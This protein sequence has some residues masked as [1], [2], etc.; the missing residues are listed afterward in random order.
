[1][2]QNL[3]KLFLIV[4]FMLLFLS[5]KIAHAFLTGTNTIVFTF[6]ILN[7]ADYWGN[8]S[9]DKD[10]PFIIKDIKGLEL[11]RKYMQVNSSDI[12]AKYFKLSGD[13]EYDDKDFTPIGSEVYPFRGNFDGNNYK[14]SG[15]NY[16]GDAQYVGLFGYVD[17]GFIENL[18]LESC[19][20]E[21]TCSNAIVGSIAG[22]ISADKI[23]NCVVVSGCVKAL[24]GTAGGIVGVTGYNAEIENCLCL[25]EEV[26]GLTQGAVI[27]NN[28]GNVTLCYFTGENLTDHEAKK[29]HTISLDK[30]ANIEV[31]ELV[32]S[33]DINLESVDKIQADTNRLIYGGQ[34]YAGA[35]VDVTIRAIPEELYSI[36][37]IEPT[38]GITSGDEYIFSMPDEDVI[39]RV[40]TIYNVSNDSSDNIISDDL[41]LSVDVSVDTNIDINIDDG[42]LI[43]ADNHSIRTLELRNNNNITFIDLTNSYVEIVDLR[44]CENL[45]EITLVS[46][47]RLE[48][49]DVSNTKL[50]TLNLQGCKNLRTL[51]CA[52]CDI[53]DLNISGC[54]LLENINFNNNS[55]TKF[56][57]SM[58]FHLERLEHENQHMQIKLDSKQFNILDILYANISGDIDA[59]EV[60]N[61]KDIEAF[62]ESGDEIAVTYDDETGEITL[63][64]EADEIH[65]KYITGFKDTSMDV[66]ITTESAG[67]NT[68]KSLLALFCCL[69]LPFVLY[70]EQFNTI[71]RRLVK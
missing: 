67:C 44:G 34:V 50:R 69:F 15:I 2:K 46:C 29:A 60:A 23:V 16:S 32:F 58:L 45:E 25:N 56:D 61:V 55:L 48:Y 51:I 22:F 68:G 39:V 28:E 63:S 12:K 30:A 19:K 27:G 10:N 13:I 49:L 33:G 54:D 64:K 18:R 57:A 37:S 31:L 38:G 43:I 36:V 70:F 3:F 42:Q 62:N 65:Y 24:D 14:I 1:M 59:N 41:P 8:V 21:S 20:F 26:T 35:S 4:F 71:L 53:A 40:G 11:I 47:E 66:K 6:E 52:S 17:G 7:I 9:G 5:S